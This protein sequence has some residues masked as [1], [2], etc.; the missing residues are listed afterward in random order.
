MAALGGRLKTIAGAAVLL[1][2]A[3]IFEPPARMMDNIAN[4]PEEAERP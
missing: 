4:F 1:R 2:T 3:T